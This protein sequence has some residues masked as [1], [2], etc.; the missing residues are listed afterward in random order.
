[1]FIKAILALVLIIAVSA[2]GGS[3]LGDGFFDFQKK[4]KAQKIVDVTRDVSN[5]MQTFKVS[6]ISNKSVVAFLQEATDPPT[7]DGL[8][9]AAVGQLRDTSKLLKGNGTV[10]GVTFHLSTYNNTSGVPGVYLSSVGTGISPDICQKINEV[11]LGDTG[12][13]VPLVP[14]AF[15]DGENLKASD[16]LTAAAAASEL[17][18]IEL[19]EGK[20]EALCFKDAATNKTAFIYYVQG[21]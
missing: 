20:K 14:L 4:A 15:P 6:E 13:L 17:K 1:M 12:T 21:L 7:S 18:I 19:I 3:I 10:D 9:N 2:L 16:L 11:V 8:Y 5:V